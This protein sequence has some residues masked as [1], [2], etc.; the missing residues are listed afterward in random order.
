M[1]QKHRFGFKAIKNNSE[2]NHQKI[3]KGKRTVTL[4]LIAL[5]LKKLDFFP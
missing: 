1:K 5:L 3:S 2:T 4:I